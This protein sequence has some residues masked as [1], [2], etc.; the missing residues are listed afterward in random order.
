ME[1][2]IISIYRKIEDVAMNEQ[3]MF[4][5]QRFILE[6][7]IIPSGFST[8]IPEIPSKPSETDKLK[9]L[10]ALS[11]YQQMTQVK[12]LSDLK[13]QFAELSYAFMVQGGE[14]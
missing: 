14:K 5:E 11:T 8:V 12:E 6:G 13:E 10:L 7:E 1:Q 9:E 4:I 3:G 2:N